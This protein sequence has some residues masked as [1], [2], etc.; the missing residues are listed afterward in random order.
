MVDSS[1]PS[2]GFRDRSL[3]LVLFGVVPRI[4]AGLLAGAFGV[5]MLNYKSPQFE[6]SSTVLMLSGVFYLS[7]TVFSVWVGIGSILARRWARALTLMVSW[8][9]LAVGSVETLY[10]VWHNLVSFQED[11]ARFQDLSPSMV[12]AVDWVLTGAAALFL[13]ALPLAF[14][15]FYRSPAVKAFCEARNPVASWADSRPLPIL[16][17]CLLLLAGAFGGFV[18]LAFFNF[19][20]L[21]CGL[22]F[23]GWAGFVLTLFMSLVHVY[24]AWGIYQRKILALWLTAVFYTVWLLP[25]ALFGTPGQIFEMYKRMNLTSPLIAKS[26]ENMSF[27]MVR[28]GILALLVVTLACLFWVRAYFEKTDSPNA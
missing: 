12:A 22:V 7:F 28:F 17:F 10:S 1:E 24:L 25:N 4:C 15:L 14:V 13:V 20:M 11:A 9:L 8:L 23:S 2:L 21:F 18:F 19:T 27:G 3:G 5:F 6:G 16:G 26:M